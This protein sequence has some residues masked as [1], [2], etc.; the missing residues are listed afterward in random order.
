[1]T[2][3]DVFLLMLI[4]VPLFLVWGTALFDIF[5]RDDIKGGMRVLWTV[6]VIFLPFLGTLIY[7]LTRPAGATAQE[8]QA[9]DTAGRQ[10]VAKYAPADNAQQ[11]ALLADLRDRGALTAQEFETEKARV[12]G[13]SDAVATGD[14][15]PRTAAGTAV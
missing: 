11:L 8:R 1:M 9:L 2:F 4:W 5:R 10:F 15:A 14:A 3:W 7:L 12:M 13:R 6:V